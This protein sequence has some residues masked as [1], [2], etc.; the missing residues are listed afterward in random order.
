[1]ELLS[2][3]EVMTNFY[4]ICSSIDYSNKQFNVIEEYKEGVLLNMFKI[5]LS[6]Q[7]NLFIVLIC[8]STYKYYKNNYTNQ[9]IDNNN[10]K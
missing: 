2:Y 6:L 7:M 1:M 3:N 10:V 5:I 8:Y 9:N 4:I